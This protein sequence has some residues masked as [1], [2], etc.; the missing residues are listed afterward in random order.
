MIK[1]IY[2]KVKQGYLVNKE[3]ALELLEKYDY[4]TL[5]NYANKL[6]EYFL[7]DDFDLCSIVNGKSG[8]CS[9]DC[10]FCAQSA[11]HSV[12]I[13]KYPLMEKEEFL[14]DATYH[15]EKGVKRYSIVTSG[16][17]LSKREIEKVCQTYKSINE[18]VKIKTCASHGLLDE[19]ELIKLK[20]AGVERYHNNLE[21]SRRHFDK[22]CTTHTYDEKIATIK[23]AQRAGLYVCSGGIMGLGESREDR[24][25]MAF[26][27]R[28]LQIKSIPLNMLNYIEG[29]SIDNSK[30]IT[31]EEFLKTIAIFRFINP[32]SYIRLAGGR[33]LLTNFGEL[34]FKGGAN[35]T[36]T[37]D[38]L[39]TCGNTIADDVKM[40]S[41]LGFK[42]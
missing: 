3:E 36:I 13:D 30:S 9:E 31:E 19:E 20:E 22:I 5:G 16:K 2:E 24:V 6:R 25:E 29:T 27:L 1:A 23:A 15:H 7:G 40:I 12:P 28:D 17:K 11:H 41:D 34:A 42:L 4:K 14:K 39:T 37:G 26:E 8:N 18:D 21:T 38:L 32:T 10:K 33:N 35:A